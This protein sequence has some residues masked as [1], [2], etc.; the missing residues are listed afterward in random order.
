M[1]CFLFEFSLTGRVLKEQNMEGVKVLKFGGTSVKTIGRI[2]HVAEI[3]AERARHSK[4]IVV[5][6]AMGD[7]TDH[8]LSLARQCS[9]TPDQREL[10]VLLS[11]GEQKSIALLALALRDIGVKARSFTGQ[12]LGIATDGTHNN[13]R[14]LDINTKFIDDALIESDVL[15]VAG[16]QGIN[17]VG[18]ITT[19]G[20]GGSDTT[21]VALAVANGGCA[22]DIYTDVDGIYTSDPNKLSEARLLRQASYDDVLALARLGAQ[23]LHPRAVELAQLYNVQL[24]VRNTF[25]QDDEGTLIEGANMIEPIRKSA[26]VAVDQQV[27]CVNAL[28]VPEDLPLLSELTD[29]LC[30]EGISVE[31]VAQ[32]GLP[33]DNA[34]VLACAVRASEVEK[35][36]QCFTKF[37]EKYPQISVVAELDIA[38]VSLI[39]RGFASDT[40]LTSNV[41]SLLDRNGVH[42]RLVSTTENSLSCWVAKSVAQKASELLHNSFCIDVAVGHTSGQTISAHSS[43]ASSGSVAAIRTSSAFRRALA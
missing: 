11:I 33:G 43:N 5:V 9:N 8:L 13:A 12:Q 35:A 28:N 34:K 3:V 37:K 30:K 25:N 2:Q 14:I 38:K 31:T 41:I 26:G 16:F 32:I 24:R 7:T 36:V 42:I 15:V 22:C 4:I 40:V 1:G 18:D 6:S 23:V 21:A 19:L 39:G 27:A 17:S 10:D 29:A 20:R